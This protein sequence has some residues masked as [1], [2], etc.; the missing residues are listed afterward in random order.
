MLSRV[1]ATAT[2]TA[3]RSFSS[4]PAVLP[5]LSYDY[6]ELEPAVSGQIMEI[7]HS[8]HHNTY[9]TNYN[10]TMEAYTDAEAAGDVAKM[11][12]LQPAIKFNGGGHVNHSIFWTNLSPNGGGAP[13]GELATLIDSEFGSF[14]DFKATFNAQTAAI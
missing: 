3:A 6:A 1:T 8:K 10:A 11:I 14:D 4:A 12:A 7:H 2:R 5:E 13:T 9:V